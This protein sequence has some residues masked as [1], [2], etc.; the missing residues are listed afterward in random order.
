[1]RAAAGEHHLDV[2]VKTGLQAHEV[3]GWAA[4]R[5]EPWVGS[6]A[7]EDLVIDWRGSADFAG[8]NIDLLTRAIRGTGC[9]DWAYGDACEALGLERPTVL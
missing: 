5:P 8:A 7:V 3:V 2:F 6:G 9:P 4:G 1:L